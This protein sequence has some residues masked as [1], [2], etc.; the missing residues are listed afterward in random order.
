MGRTVPLV[1]LPAQ[2]NSMIEQLAENAK[3]QRTDPAHW[4]PP[5]CGEIDLQIKAD[6]SWWYQGSVIARPALVKLFASILR[7]DS[8]QY[9][10]V[11]PVEK[12][13]IQVEDAPF[14]VVDADIDEPGTRQQQV[15]LRTQTEDSVIL[16]KEHPLR[17][18][19]RGEDVRPYVLVRDGLWGLL[20]RPCYYRLVSEVESLPDNPDEFGLLSD[21]IWHKFL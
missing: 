15:R 8:G 13:R 19:V 7:Y 9:Y 2:V 6:G 4:D 14:F 5:F 18:D 12:V 16:G 10:L 20:S 11:T 21:G 17:I 3:K 1:A